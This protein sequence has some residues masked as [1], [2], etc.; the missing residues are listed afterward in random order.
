MNVHLTPEAEQIITRKVES[1]EY[2]SPDAVMS[3]AV[4]LL[5]AHEHAV[6]DVRRKIEAGWQS[7]K[8]GRTSDG[9]AFFAELDAELDE[10]DR[11]GP[12]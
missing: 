1:G 10:I 2:S 12:L 9:E 6:E 5:D 11:R 8:A 3:E 7:L 4:R